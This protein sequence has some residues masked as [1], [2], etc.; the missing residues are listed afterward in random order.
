MRPAPDPQCERVLD[1]LDVFLDGELAC[2]A[3]VELERHLSFCEA[4][5]D[6]AEV[7]K[8]L[9][10]RVRTAVNHSAAPAPDF[11]R[12][13]RASLGNH[14]TGRTSWSANLAIAATLVL[15]VS[16]AVA[17]QFGH[18]RFTVESRDAYIAAISQEVGGAMRVGLGDHVHC[19]V[20][21]R[22]SKTPVPVEKIAADMGPEF[23]ELVP[24]MREHVPADYCVV[25]GH[26]CRYRGRSFVHV[27]MYNGSQLLSLV[28]TKRRPGEAFEKDGVPAIIESGMAMYSAGVQRFSITGFETA[29]H[30]VYIVSDLGSK[31]N[32]ALL[33]AVAPQVRAV[34]KRTAS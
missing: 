14:G 13:I 33:A 4:C 24:V 5:A 8:R 18:F 9:R 32:T 22:L 34:L 10:V 6:A 2:D 15:A 21:R 20:F 12:R 3:H 27:S 31:Q 28:I 30:L 7:R 25:L 23:K 19:S 26:R 17:Y 1:K 11:E 16:G 29:T